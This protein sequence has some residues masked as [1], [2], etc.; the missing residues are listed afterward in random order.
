[1]QASGAVN[2]KISL[3][4]YQVKSP[5][6]SVKLLSEVQDNVARGERSEAE[7]RKFSRGGAQAARVGLR[8]RAIIPAG[9]SGRGGYLACDGGAVRGRGRGGSGARAAEDG[10]KKKNPGTGQNS[11]T[12]IPQIAAKLRT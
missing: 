4:A 12:E 2:P 6:F 5:F 1:L 7:G 9:Q 11:G 10:A 3:L 8:N